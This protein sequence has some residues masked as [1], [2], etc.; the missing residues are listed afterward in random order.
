MHLH[1]LRLFT[2][3]LQELNHFYAETLGFPITSAA[4]G[5]ITFRAGSSLF[6]F[7]RCGAPSYYHFAF[8]IPSFQIREALEWLGRRVEVLRDGDRQIIDFS[9]WNAEAV[10]FADPAGNIVEFIAR[11]DRQLRAGGP[12]SID[13]MEGISEIGLPV[14]DVRSTFDKLH[15]QTGL[16]KY[17]GDYTH[18]CAAGDP[19]GL[20]IIVDEASKTWYPTDKPAR[21]FPLWVSFSEAGMKYELEFAEKQGVQLKNAQ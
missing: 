14:A 3:K 13:N 6:N 4:A 11:R 1:H 19:R 9:N 16:S 10:Y 17:W 7:S 18:F 21:S 12:F 8:N 20:F 15:R 5:T 2:D